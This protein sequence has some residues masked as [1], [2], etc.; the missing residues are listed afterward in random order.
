MNKKLAI[1]LIFVAFVIGAIGGA[2]AMRSFY[3]S[4][5]LRFAS[6]GETSKIIND[7][8]VLTWIRKNDVTNAVEFLEN[9]LDGSLMDFSIL[10]ND[11]PKSKIDPQ[12]L[13]SLRIAK[14]YRDKFPYTNEDVEISQTI[15]N[16]FLLLDVKTNK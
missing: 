14:S 10:V 6:S 7:V 4:F 15:S 1:V 11:V 5:I 13:K 9:D 3:N 16:G 12:D 8:T 2:W